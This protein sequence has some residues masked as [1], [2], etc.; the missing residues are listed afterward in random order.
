MEEELGIWRARALKAEETPAA[1]AH[2]KG[3]AAHAAAPASAEL[4]QARQR[5]GN[6]EAENQQLRARIGAAR[7]QI[8][9]LRTRLHFV[10]EHSAGDA[11]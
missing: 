5:I 1:P 2:G 6:L 7:E 9:R 11:A 8:E 4:A 3:K 10:E